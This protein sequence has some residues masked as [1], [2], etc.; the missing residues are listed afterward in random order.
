MIFESEEMKQGEVPL[1]AS[2]QTSCEM[3]QNGMLLQT[4]TFCLLIALLLVVIFVQKLY[5]NKRLAKCK[6]FPST[7]KYAQQW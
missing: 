1:Q 6:L 4:V 5:Y 7:G 2:P 3:L